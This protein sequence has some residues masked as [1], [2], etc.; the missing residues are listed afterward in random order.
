MRRRVD[1]CSSAVSRNGGE[2]LAPRRVPRWHIGEYER[3]RTSAT[4]ALGA[5]PPGRRSVP[6]GRCLH[7]ESIGA[8]ES[9]DAADAARSPRRPGRST[10][11]SAI[12]EGG[13]HGPQSRALGT[14]AW[15]SAA[16]EG[17]S[18][19]EPCGAR[20]IGSDQ[21]TGNSLAD[22]GL[23]RPLR[24][25]RDRRLLPLRRMPRERTPDRIANQHRLLRA[26]PRQYR[27]GKTRYRNGGMSLRCGRN[28]E[29]RAGEQIQPYACERSIRACTS[30]SG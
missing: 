26:R 8:G 7:L 30:V 19:G 9:D 29:E 13:D 16:G 22:L 1:A 2:G 28:V 17:V 11:R 27:R 12:G 18:R 24:G 21:L 23:A 14:C 4:R 6:R 25:A 3:T 5:L 10:R 15:R 20:E